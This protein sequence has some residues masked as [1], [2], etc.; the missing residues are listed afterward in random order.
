MRTRTPAARRSGL[1][2]LVIAA[3]AAA[4]RSAAAPPDR[5]AGGPVDS[6]LGINLSGP[7]DYASEQPFVDVFK[8]SRQWISQKKGQPWGQGPKLERDANGWIRRLEPDCWAETPLCT[9]PANQYPA[10]EYVCL[11]E[12][13]GKVELWGAV[14]RE[15]SR[16]AGRIVFEVDPARGGF[17]VRLRETDPSDPVRNIRVLMP[18][19]EQ[20]Y[21]REPFNPRFLK[22]WAGFNT[23]RFMDWMLTNGSQVRGWAERPTPAYCNYTEKGVPLEVMIDLANRLNVNPWFCMPHQ[24]TDDYVRRFAAQVRR[25][26]APSLKAHVEYSNEVWNGGFAQNRYANEEGLKLKL[27]EKPWEAGWRFY[28]RRSVQIFRLWEEAFGGKQRL[29]RVLASQAANPYISGVELQFEDTAKQCDALAIAPYLSLNL[30]PDG[31]PSAGEVAG[32]SVDQVLDHLEQKSLPECVGWMKSAKEL[33]DRHGVKLMAYEAGQHAVGVAG[34]ENNDAL[35]RV[36]TAANRHERMG[37]LYTRYLDAWKETGGDLCCLFSSVGNWSKW[38]SWGL[39]EHNED[40]TP[41]YRAVLA[42]NAANR[43]A[44][45]SR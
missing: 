27:A 45:A 2:I 12:G 25:D 15:V 6:R 39:L 18:G 33:A 23:F 35:T 17:W 19:T 30:A 5:R 4:C 40:D 7:A 16:A 3:L 38:G 13:T 8:L 43:R 37:R 41:K 24:A 32:W 26:L 9:L 10:G 14:K 11:Y 34:G 28:A 42:W 1:L 20:T 21:R 22:R 29:V 31:K 36:L 44:P